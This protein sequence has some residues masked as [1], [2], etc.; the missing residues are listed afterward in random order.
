L[1]FCRSFCLCSVINRTFSDLLEMFYFFSICRSILS[2]SKQDVLGLF[3][4]N[5]LICSSQG[6]YRMF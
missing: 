3:L 1:T 4:I 6:T 5:F 2:L